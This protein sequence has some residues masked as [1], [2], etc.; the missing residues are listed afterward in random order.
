VLLNGRD[1][2]K[3]DDE[4]MR[5]VRLD[6]IALVTQAAM[7]ALNPVM[8]IEEQLTDGLEDHGINDSKE[9]RRTRVREM[10]ERVGLEASVARMYPH[11]LSGGMK[12]RVAI[13][14]ATALG[15]EVIVADEPTSALDVVVQ[16]QV[17]ATLGRLQKETG[18]SVILVGHDMGLVGQFADR[19]GVMY[20]GKLV[21]LE[22]VKQIVEEP[23]HPYSRLLLESV[24]G[25]DEKRERLVSIPGMPPPLIDLPT[26]CV[27]HPRCPEAMPKCATREPTLTRM[28]DGRW[29]ACHLCTNADPSLEVNA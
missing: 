25:L 11:E 2:L 14:T 23:L 16:R 7:N 10:L 27:F 29:V 26:G 24:P 1:L 28:R 12:Q 21:D 22:P 18:A 15:P 20:A 5:L 3:L 13:A 6:R 8:R 4:E 19:V 9:Q 17:M